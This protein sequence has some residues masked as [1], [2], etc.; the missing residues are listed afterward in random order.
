LGTGAL[1]LNEV[2]RLGEERAAADSVR[3]KFLDE[4]CRPDKDTHFF[5][6]TTFPYNSWVVVG[7]FWPPKRMQESLF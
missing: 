4:M 3:T 7:V 2:A 5:M 6:G 1:W